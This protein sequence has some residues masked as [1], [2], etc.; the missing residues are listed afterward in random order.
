MWDGTLALPVRLRKYRIPSELALLSER[1]RESALAKVVKK[2]E[3]IEAREKPK[4]DS[5][6]E[7]YIHEKREEAEL[8]WIV[9]QHRLYGYLENEDP[10]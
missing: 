8:S 1:S 6:L 4:M 5:L 3:E 10:S 2:A 7:E 9:T